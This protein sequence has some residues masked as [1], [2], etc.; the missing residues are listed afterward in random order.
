[1]KPVLTFNTVSIL[2]AASRAMS[3]DV[4]HMVIPVIGIREGVLN[5]IFYPEASLSTLA[6]RWN[7]VPIP[8][9]HPK[10]ADGN[11]VTANSAEADA[12]QNIGKFFNVAFD[13]K[14]KALK[15]E[16]WINIQKA[17]DLGHADLLD[18]LDK[19][20]NI[21]VSTGLWTNYE[22][23]VGN[24]RG[25]NYIGIVNE[26]TPDHLAILP[27]EKG[28][29]S[30][31][32][33]CGTFLLNADKEKPCC[34]SCAADQTKKKT[35]TG[36]FENAFKRISTALGF[37]A[38]EISHNDIRSKLSTQLQ[39]NF[40]GS[41]TWQYIVDVFPDFF[42][43]EQDDLLFKQPYLINNDET[44]AID[45]T[46]AQVMIKRQYEEVSPK[47]A[48]NQEQTK[49]MKQTHTIA[50]AALLAANSI[51][52]AQHKEL[53][54][55]P[56]DLLDGILK[57]N[58]DTAIESDKHADPVHG[59][60][61]NEDALLLQELRQD[62]KARLTRLRSHI[63][64]NCKQIPANVVDTMTINQLEETAHG[65]A[66]TDS[67]TD[68]SFAGGSPDLTNNQVGSKD[69]SAPSILLAPVKS[70]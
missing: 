37:N 70:A 10:D 5:G 25:K 3:G 32:D 15:G 53:G 19:G 2:A 8:V 20:E 55:L 49:T 43:Y 1:M 67:A 36:M 27:D 47:I 11:F 16:M 13:P 56:D 21:N 22:P 34:G 40:K 59:I 57:T 62:R 52:E 4:E 66:P 12:E 31:D 65:I 58:A 38:N 41:K 48:T 24:F 18:R 63:K 46:P 35:A 17:T 9:R 54:L 7:G 44:V 69:Y 23:Q 6:E 30:V 33:G 64:A 14:T 51:T 39:L 26:F 61:T 28:A 50:L 60:M 29:C 68:F 45:G 42:V